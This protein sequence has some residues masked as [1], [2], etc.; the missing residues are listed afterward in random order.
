MVS[1]Y[2]GEDKFIN[3]RLRGRAAIARRNTKKSAPVDA[4]FRV[5]VVVQAVA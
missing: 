1:I 3:D 2:E 5:G 4:A